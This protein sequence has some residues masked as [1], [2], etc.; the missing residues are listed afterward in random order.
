MFLIPLKVYARKRRRLA[1][2]LEAYKGESTENANT[3]NETH[4]ED[5]KRQKRKL[6][7][8]ARERREKQTNHFSLWNEIKCQQG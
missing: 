5:L 8:H 2:D 7:E 1:D 4:R 3:S 6:L